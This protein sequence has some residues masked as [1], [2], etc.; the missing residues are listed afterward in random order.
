M[1]KVYNMNK[2]K[3]NLIFLCSAAGVLI[4]L[5]ILGFSRASKRR[6]GTPVVVQQAQSEVVNILPAAATPSPSSVPTV[7]DGAVTLLVNRTPVLTLLSENEAQKLLWTYLMQ[8][9][10]APEGET[11]VSATFDGELIIG[12]AAMDAKVTD[13]DDA[14]TLLTNQPSIVPV[15]LVTIRT[16]TAGADAERT[17]TDEP[18]LSKGS[19]M[20]VQLGSGAR[21]QTT[22]KVVYVAGLQQ[23]A[24]DPVQKTVREAR[25][26]I[27]KNGTFT[28]KDPSGEP[29]KKEGV[30]G[31]GKGE[32]KLGYPMRGNVTS[33]FGFRDGNMHNGLDI[34]A[35]AGTV[36]AAPGEGVV[37]Y[38]GVRGAY[39][40]V[41]DID[42]GNGFIS[43]LTHLEDVGVE[44]N[45][46]VFAGD[47][48]GVLA[49]TSDNGKKAHLHYELLVDG[50]PNNPVFYL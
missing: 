15:R 43:R 39:G 44:L 30:A 37:V 7:P 25:A 41:V 48:V 5:S 22:T 42:H 2:K 6:A 21:I 28:R 31:K 17:E 26:T 49:A 34:S 12:D 46:R 4:V 35:K 10:T 3:L 45:Q 38:C 8:N 9:S 47:A 11:F 32:L 23:S 18:S 24:D 14:L 1:K 13:Y 33:Y 19:R 36:V 27:L 50:I 16:E 40:L 20:I 29:D